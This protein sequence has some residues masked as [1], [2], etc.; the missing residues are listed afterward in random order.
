MKY[1]IILMMLCASF[2]LR[3]QQ[4]DTVEVSANTQGQ[5]LDITWHKT[6][7]L[8]FPSSIQSADRGDSYVLAEKVKGVDNVL[9]V[10]AGK[11]YFEPSNLHVITTDGNVYNF[12]VF[13][14]DEPAVLT[15]DMRR[16]GPYAVA[17]FPGVSL[18]SKQLSEQAKIVEGSYPFL[19]GVKYHA[20]GITFTL[21]GIYIKDDVL[22]F[23]Y[24]IKNQTAIGFD[25]GSLRF[26]IRDKKKAK[27]TAEQDKEIKPI[28]VS[29]SGVTENDR[30]AIIVAAFPKFTIADNK[31]FVTEMMEAGGDRNPACKLD[32]KKLLK[33]KKLIQ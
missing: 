7:L 16:D 9:K 21:D 29:H 25:E 6:T 5:K 30:G 2:T 3:A 14:A 31:N 23:R 12:N 15:L 24:W 18:N 20:N 26:Y 13:Y 28:H 11:E 27:R 4:A 33:A 17:E 8:I 10:K 19:N 22:F 32:Q 1:L